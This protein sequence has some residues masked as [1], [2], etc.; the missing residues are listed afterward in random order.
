MLY[1]WNPLARSP[2]DWLFCTQHHAPGSQLSCLE[3]QQFLALY[4][5]VVIPQRDVPQSASLVIYWGASGLPLVLRY[6]E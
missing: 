3:Y 5:W 4:G 2:G 1:K 6:H